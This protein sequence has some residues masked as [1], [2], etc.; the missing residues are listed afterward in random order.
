LPD[1]TRA[2]NFLPADD[3]KPTVARMVPGLIGEAHAAGSFFRHTHF[4]GARA[5]V[6][7]AVT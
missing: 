4:F 5:V 3:V 7:E 6:A 1:Q 2:A